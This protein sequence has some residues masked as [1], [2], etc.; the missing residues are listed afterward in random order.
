MEYS[1]QF[2]L[3][4]F[5]DFHGIMLTR[6]KV[7]DRGPWRGDLVHSFCLTVEENLAQGVKTSACVLQPCSGGDPWSCHHLTAP[8]SLCCAQLHR[9]CLAASLGLHAFLFPLGWTSNNIQSVTTEL[10]HSVIC[11]FYG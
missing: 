2:A 5:R 7:Q 4:I 8:S 3:I 6:S 9:L 11:I 1:L 10:L